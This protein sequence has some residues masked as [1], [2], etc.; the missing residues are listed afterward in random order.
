[1]H[2]MITSS[3]LHI[4]PLGKAAAWSDVRR[5]EVHTAVLHKTP[6]GYAIQRSPSAWRR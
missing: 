2:R 3:V 5:Q 1:M 6:T 4:D